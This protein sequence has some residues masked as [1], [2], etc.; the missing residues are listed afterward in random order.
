MPASRDA[1][2][3]SLSNFR[4]P[5]LSAFRPALRLVSF[6]QSST[7]GANPDTWRA[8]T[9]TKIGS[10]AAGV[11]PF[12]RDS[13]ERKFL[14]ALQAFISH[15]FHGILR[16]RRRAILSYRRTCRRGDKRQI[17]TAGNE[18]PKRRGGA[19][20]GR[21]HNTAYNEGSRHL[22]IYEV[23]KERG[24][25]RVSIVVKLLHIS[26]NSSYPISLCRFDD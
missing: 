17:P 4:P 11:S 23:G 7:S 13:R 2:S 18:L 12:A 3:S 8:R 26:R 15:D 6:T 16:G 14:R 9:R 5:F 20:E 21:A 10:C 22:G 25:C 24:L 1:E 19:H